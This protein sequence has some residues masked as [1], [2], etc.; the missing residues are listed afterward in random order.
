MRFPLAPDETYYWEWSRRPAL[1]YY[2]QG[3]LV[4]WWMK[5]GTIPFG[6]TVLGVRFGTVLA[7][8]FTQAAVYSL[9]ARLFGP[10]VGLMGMLPLLITPLGLAG[11]L[12]ATYDPLVVMFWAVAMASA[13]R[14]VLSNCR[15]AWAVCG[16]SVGFGLLSK[17]TMFLFL[18]AMLGWLAAGSS[19]R[20]WLRRPQPYLA[21][22]LALAVFSP[23][24][25]WQ[26]QNQWQTFGHLFLL[27][28]KGLDQPFA[29]R[30]GDFLGSQ[31]AILT[32]VLIVLLVAAAWQF[33]PRGRI[34][35][36]Q[37][38]SVLFWM[39]VPLLM[40]FTA[41]VAKSK[42][43]ANWAACAWLTPGIALAAA[44]E[45]KSGWWGRRQLWRLGCFS[46]L[47]L[48]LPVA[49]PE[50]RV[51]LHLPFPQKWDQMNKL[52]GGAELGAAIDRE[53]MKMQQR[54]GR[55]PAVASTTYDLAARAAFY[56]SGRPAV[57]CLF[58]GTRD[59]SYRAFNRTAD[60]QE[61]GDA[62][63]V[64][65]RGPDDPLLPPFA[66]VFSKVEAAPEV[67][68]VYRRPLYTQPVRISHLYR[69]YGY[70]PNPA[71]ETPSGG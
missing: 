5:L 44:V 24:L 43:Q 58:V 39:S 55:L 16:A 54:T 29:R 25:W 11:G 70:R 32:P 23:N 69:C 42:V 56:T 38:A 8:V 28:G 71:V 34:L 60:L 59:N 57:R 41:M 27:T 26:S 14:A 48:T 50:I 45:R 36:S 37:G 9:G 46:A 12:T 62:V 22:L 53:R 33:R 21:L 10:R 68:V 40:L 61:G 17:H 19:L 67:V 52:Y 2:D 4:A 65:D 47:L 66:K 49:M 7:A 63:V 20:H 31:A 15:G 51:L 6:D 13:A 18:P 35:S 1:G 64:D 30:L 3:P